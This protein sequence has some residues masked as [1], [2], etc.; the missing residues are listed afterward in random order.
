M[1][2]T[3][4]F[5]RAIRE[6]PDLTDETQVPVLSLRIVLALERSIAKRRLIRPD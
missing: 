5:G 3:A 2:E 4:F 1:W 6:D